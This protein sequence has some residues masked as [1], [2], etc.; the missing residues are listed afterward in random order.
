MLRGCI[1][2]TPLFERWAIGCM[3]VSVRGQEG[4]GVLWVRRNRLTCNRHVHAAGRFQQ[5]C[6]AACGSA[7]RM[8][9]AEQNI[10]ATL[11]SSALNITDGGLYCRRG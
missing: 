9:C 3:A 6:S 11:F 7:C 10:G 5:W 1:L 8:Q 4:R 2:C